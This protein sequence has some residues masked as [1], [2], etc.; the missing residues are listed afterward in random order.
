[1]INILQKHAI[2]LTTCTLLMFS[3]MIHAS[4]MQQEKAWDFTVYLDD[5]VIGYHHFKLTRDAKQQ[6]MTT[7]AAFDVNFMFFNLYSYRHD[8]TEIW[9]D[10]CLNKLSATTDDNGEMQFVQLDMDNEGPQAILKTHAGTRI[11][12]QCLRSF[13]YWNPVLLKTSQLLNSQTGELIDVRFDYLG[14]DTLRLHNSNIMAERFHL[15][16][17]N[18]AIDLWYTRDMH[19]LALQS[20]LDN[21][22]TL[23]Y[24]LK[25]ETAP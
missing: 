11:V 19:W 20:I 6:V 25:P 14:P 22:N 2:T 13:A 4:Q 16:G 7:R 18:I 5:K 3:N 17:E 21:G 23:R 12:N 15:Q 1:M 24:E 10:N 8:N 9:S